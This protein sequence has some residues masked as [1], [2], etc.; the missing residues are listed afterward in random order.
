MVR[1]EAVLDSWK[2]IR[3]DTAQAVEEFPVT[4]FDYKPG[5]DVM[6]FG[7]IATHILQAGHALTGALLDGVDNLAVPEFRAILGKYIAQLPPHGNP[8]EL[9]SALR[10]TVEARC[11][12]LAAM[13]PDFYSAMMTRFDGQTVT[14]LEMLQTIKEH[15]LTHRSQMFMYLRLK[16]LVPATTRR[17][18]AKAKA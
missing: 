12:E 15:E 8:A 9:A 17:R 11:A 2:T 14:R 13:P 18:L 5:E 6:T 4:D 3:S 1:T 16:G 10:S 7:E